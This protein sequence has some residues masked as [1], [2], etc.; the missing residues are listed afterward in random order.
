MVVNWLVGRE[1]VEEEQRGQR[2]A[3]YGAALLREL[4]GRLRVEFG[5]GYGLDNLEH[6][7]RFFLDYPQLLAE[8]FETAVRNSIVVDIAAKWGPGA[9]HLNLSWSHYRCLLRVGRRLARNFYEIEAIKNAWSVCE[10]SA[11]AARE[12]TAPKDKSAGKVDARCPA[13]SRS[14]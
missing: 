3:G 1:I 7:R 2:R 4:A 13:W 12:L 10:L 14:A 11:T 5:A 8:I 9:L 6:C